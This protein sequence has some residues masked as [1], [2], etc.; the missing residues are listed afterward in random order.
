MFRSK[1]LKKILLIAACLILANFLYQEVKPEQTV[2]IINEILI[3]ADLE[4]VGPKNSGPVFVFEK[5]LTI[6]A[7]P[8]EP[9]S[10]LMYPS[11]IILDDDGY[12]YITDSGDVQRIVVFSPD[13]NYMRSFGGYGSGPGEFQI[14]SISSLEDD[15]LH[16][17]DQNLNRITRYRTTGELLDVTALRTGGLLTAFL[18][19]DLGQVITIRSIRGRN[20]KIRN[21]EDSFYVG[22]EVTIRDSTQ[23]E[24][25]TIV[26]ESERYM[27]FNKKN[28]RVQALY[29]APYPNAA[30][31]RH[32][33]IVVTS[34]A[35]PV[36]NQYN[37]SGEL[38]RQIMLDL[39]LEL[40]T[41]ADRLRAIEYRE[42]QMA[43]IRNPEPGRYD[44]RE[45]EFAEQKAYWR[46]VMMDEHG[47]IWLIRLW[48]FNAL[49]QGLGTTCYVIHPN[50][51]WLA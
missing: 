7:D 8:S 41:R 25:F 11:N 5:I 2:S 1:Y 16:L 24:M 51:E 39:P 29:F 22:V 20:G 30:F 50:G 14:T 47:Y 32:H 21:R 35:Q 26:S 36:V 38:T 31:S 10:M 49:D 27:A 42:A 18:L 34:G 9:K 48:D 23:T 3:P 13:G 15:V 33:G 19:P 17:F 12:I 43:N 40:V 44:S 28:R 6:E 4:P 37:L 45:L 46:H